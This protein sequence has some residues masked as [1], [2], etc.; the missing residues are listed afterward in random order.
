MLCVC[1]SSFCSGHGSGFMGQLLSGAA[2]A[3]AGHVVGKHFGGHRGH[4]G[5][6]Q[7]SHQ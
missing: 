1:E 4:G 2:A 5:G 7:H 6:P 3:T